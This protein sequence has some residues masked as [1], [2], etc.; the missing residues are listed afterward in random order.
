MIWAGTI[1]CAAIL[2][3]LAGLSDGASF[4]VV[5]GLTGAA[6]ASIHGDSACSRGCVQ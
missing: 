1:L 3:S 2:A 5:T 4:G 6:W